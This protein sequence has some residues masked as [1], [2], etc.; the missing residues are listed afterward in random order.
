M[1]I[2]FLWLAMS[3]ILTLNTL[4]GQAWGDSLS[5]RVEAMGGAAAGII[6]ESTDLTLLNLGNPAG[7]AF[8]RV[9]NRLDLNYTY[10]RES[11]DTPIMSSISSLNEISNPG[12]GYHGL[13][14]WL[15][16]SLVITG[17]G[18]YEIGG[19]EEH[20]PGTDDIK[21]N[22]SNVAGEIRLAGKIKNIYLGCTVGLAQDD[23]KIDPNLNLE[24]KHITAKH[25]A[26]HVGAAYAGSYSQ[27]LWIE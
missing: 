27:K 2:L 26:W 9:E 19:F 4:A 21:E 17:S 18:L 22:F 10:M 16:D 6:D 23:T 5:N 3:M 7:L 8:G 13:T 24:K 14:Y 1:K 20:E 15:T 11:K 25:T 12:G